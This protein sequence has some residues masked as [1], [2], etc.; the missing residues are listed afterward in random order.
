VTTRDGTQVRGDAFK[1]MKE[2]ETAGTLYLP[3]ASYGGKR[4]PQSAEKY[5]NQDW[6]FKAH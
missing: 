4:R 5:R 6:V 1:R 3:T 2:E